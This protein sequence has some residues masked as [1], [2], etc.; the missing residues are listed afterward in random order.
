MLGLYGIMVSVFV[1]REIPVTKAHLNNQNRCTVTPQ[2]LSPLSLTQT[3][4]KCGGNSMSSSLENM[5]IYRSITQGEKLTNQTSTP[6]AEVDFEVFGARE[7]RDV[8]KSRAHC[9]R[10]GF[11][12]NHL[13][14]I[15]LNEIRDHY[16]LRVGLPTYLSQMLGDLG[17]VPIKNCTLYDEADRP[18]KLSSK[19]DHTQPVQRFIAKV[20]HWDNLPF[21]IE[22]RKGGNT[23]QVEVRYL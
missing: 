8:L 20:F 13:I 15:T 16:I 3:P 6:K 19:G 21:R 10:A 11:P 14:I 23:D 1:L 12:S 7:I 17:K 18:I 2:A 9:L 5:A 22:A 4:S